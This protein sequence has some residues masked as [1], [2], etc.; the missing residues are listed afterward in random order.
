M[1]NE[2]WKFLGDTEVRKTYFVMDQSSF[3]H[4]NDDMIPTY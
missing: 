1:S 4:D 2:T 3:V